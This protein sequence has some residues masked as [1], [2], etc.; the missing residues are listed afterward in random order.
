MRILSLEKI[1]YSKLTYSKILLSRIRDSDRI[2]CLNLHNRERE[3][4][5]NR[6][7]TKFRFRYLYYFQIDPRLKPFLKPYALRTIRDIRN[8]IRPYLERIKHGMLLL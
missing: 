7:L 4:I 1:Q 8:P 6:F 2:Y 5:E 3:R